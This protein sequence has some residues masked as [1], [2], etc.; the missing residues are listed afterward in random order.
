VDSLLHPSRHG[1]VVVV[2]AQP[3]LTAQL[4]A[5]HPAEREIAAGLSPLRQREWVAGRCALREALRRE[6]LLD[7]APL[8]RD[9]RGA[10]RVP[11][12]ALGSLSHKGDWAAALVARRKQGCS[13]GLDLEH[14]KGPRVDISRRILTAAELDELS[15]F[16]E[17]EGLAGRAAQLALRF[18]LKEAVYKAI[19][20]WV[21][22]YVGFREV[23][24]TLSPSSADAGFGRVR[25]IDPRLV[26]ELGDRTT[27]EVSWSRL[28]EHWVSTAWAERG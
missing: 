5:L 7:A 21:R 1:T 4:A 18:S 23:E 15:R 27:L 22:R 19:D 14:T 25:A 13:L 26:D 24:L 16:Q 12:E 3:E 6:E 9:E 11:A 8:L 10:P 2:A 17:Q 28:G 20:P